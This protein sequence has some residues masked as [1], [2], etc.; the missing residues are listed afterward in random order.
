MPRTST[1]EQ[2]AALLEGLA[3]MPAD[4]VSL[5]RR[6]LALKE[7]KDKIQQEMDDIRDTFAERLE[8]EG[9]QGYMLSGKVKARRS[10]VTTH[11]ADTNI[12]KTKYPKIWAAVM[13]T[14]K[15]VRVDIT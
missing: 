8:A 9:L 11:R 5:R 4:L 6:R 2:E 12:L 3:E 13:K 7:R 10:E 14:T 15:S 1:I